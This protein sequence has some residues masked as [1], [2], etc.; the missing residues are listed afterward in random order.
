M[1]QAKL[2]SKALRKLTAA[3]SNTAMVFIN[4]T[5]EAV[6]V[7]FGK[8]T[9][10]PG[11]R[12]MSHYAGM[13]LELVRTEQLRRKGQTVDHKT[14]EIKDGNVVFGHRVLVRA[15]KD[16]TG[17]IV[18]PN[19]ETTF[20]YDYE[21]G[22]HDHIEDLIYLGRVNGFI[23]SKKKGKVDQ[24]WVE[25]YEDEAQIGRT[26]FKRWLRKNKAVAEELEEW[27]RSFV[28]EIEPEDEEEPENDALEG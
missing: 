20:V 24:W 28:D 8:K 12:A 2:M 7:M 25:E 22:H 5:R 26:R 3:N 18:R 15:E 19:D 14:G 1:E 21:K 13:R 9:L 6:G 11:G 23:K 27:I 17:G 16:K 10:A 4:Q